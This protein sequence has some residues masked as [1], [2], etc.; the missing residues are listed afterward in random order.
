L[1]D[2]PHYQIGRDSGEIIVRQPLAGPATGV[3]PPCPELA[4]AANV[5]D[6]AGAA[7]L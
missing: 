1:G 7:A 2:A 5:C 4:A 3:M 6:Y